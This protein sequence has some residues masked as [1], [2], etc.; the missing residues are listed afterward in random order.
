M[1]RSITIIAI[2]LLLIACQST[3]P[4]V[5]VNEPS[6]EQQLD[7]NIAFLQAEIASGK[8]ERRYDL[9]LMYSASFDQ[10]TR[11]LAKPILADLVAEDN[12]DAIVLFAQLEFLGKLGSTSDRLFNKYYK[13]IKDN[14]PSVVKNYDYEK[15]EMENTVALNFLAIKKL[16]DGNHHLCEQPLDQSINQLKSDANTYLVVKYFN[17]CL[18]D[19][20]INNSGQRLRVISKFQE[21]NCSTKEEEKVCISKGYNELSSGLDSAERSFVVAA[22]LRNIYKS[23]KDLLRNKTGVQKR[24]PSLKTAKVV[25]KAFEAYNEKNID[26][27]CQILINYMHEETKL[28]A[29]DTA[30]MQQFLAKALLL[31][32]T[33]TDTRLAIEYANK[34]LKSDELSFKEHWGLFDLLSDVYLNN[35]E[36]TK[37]ID[38][39]GNYILENQGD[40]DLIPASSLSEAN[41]HKS[42]KSKS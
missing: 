9:A 37:Y 12:I 42:I 41:N 1:N 28:S 29:F 15:A 27:S 24:S 18:E 13:S 20:S 11:K 36:Y 30:Y 10:N 2:S 32:D 5:T 25:T 35:E 33:N 4:K 21:I 7:S 14:S 19:Y 3:S 23:H 26:K 39:I 8:K 38:M 40:M 22:A 16:Y 34:A 17:R 31:K 6:K